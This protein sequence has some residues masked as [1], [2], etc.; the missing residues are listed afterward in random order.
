M[1]ISQQ[2]TDIVIQWYCWKTLCYDC[3]C[4]YRFL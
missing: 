4:A 1:I 3:W 2:E